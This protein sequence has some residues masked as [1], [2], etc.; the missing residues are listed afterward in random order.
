MN[1]IQR[2]SMTLAACV[3]IALAALSMTHRFTKERIALTQHHWLTKNLQAVLPEG[4]YD[5][6]PLLSMHTIKADAL[7]GDQAVEVYPVYKDQKPYAVVLTVVAPDGYNGDIQLLLGLNAN[8]TIIGARV[9]SHKETPGLGDDLE[10]KRSDW[11]NDFSN[12]SLKSTISKH[13]NVRKE[14]GSF[15]AFT[16]ATIT[17]RAVVHAIF[18]A[19]RWYENNQG[20]VFIS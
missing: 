20:R 4:P 5:N 6:D 12:K 16:G 17:P 18:R 15:D 13:W 19:L 1:P 14:G 8:G 10:L 9:T 2:A 3:L 11:I 7:G